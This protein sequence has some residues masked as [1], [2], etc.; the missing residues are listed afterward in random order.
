MIGARRLSL[1]A[2][3]LAAIATVVSAA[4]P[5][6][7]DSIVADYVA[8]R[9]GLAK[10]RSIQTLRQKGRA[11][12]GPGRQALV[13]REL[14]RP[15]KTRF[16]FTVQGITGVYLSNGQRGWE[17][18]PFDGETEPRSLPEEVLQEAREQADIEGPLV[19]W[20]AKG[21]RVELAGREIVG[22]REAYKLKLTLKSGATRHEY[23]DVKSHYEVRMDCTRQIHGRPVLMTTTFGDHRKAG[24]IVFPYAVE[25]AAAGRPQTLR[26][27]VDKIEVNPPLSDARFELPDQGSHE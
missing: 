17:V 23:I 14:K 20:K 6:T 12:A 27:V 9:G 21:H 15:E 7:V 3:A 22:G 18:S 10:I 13:L 16:E 11:I 2:I 19:D 1:F 26:V 25:I 24:G 8:A 4:P 5:P